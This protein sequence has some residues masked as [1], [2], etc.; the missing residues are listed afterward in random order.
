MDTPNIDAALSAILLS[1]IG[2]VGELRNKVNN[3]EAPEGLAVRA[4][5]LAYVAQTIATLNHAGVT[6]IDRPFLDNLL[7]RANLEGLLP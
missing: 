6:S 1:E 3:G 2:S 7:S 4:Q 5:T